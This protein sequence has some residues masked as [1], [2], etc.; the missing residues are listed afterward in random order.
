MLIPRP[1]SRKEVE[2][3]L[4]KELERAGTEDSNIKNKVLITV[5]LILRRHYDKNTVATQ[6]R[7]FYVAKVLLKSLFPAHEE[8]KRE[9]CSNATRTVAS[10]FKTD[11][12]ALGVKSE[13]K[14]VV[15]GSVTITCVNGDEIPL[16]GV[17]PKGHVR[18]PPFIPHCRT[19]SKLRLM[20][21]ISLWW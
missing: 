10:T 12:F 19:S 18:D 14:G 9:T 11:F 2:K 13:Q 3:K 4:K 6:T 1:T 16:R 20:K 8:L 17:G 15:F 7:I 21:S 5:M